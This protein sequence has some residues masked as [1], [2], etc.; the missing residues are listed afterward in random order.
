MAEGENMGGVKVAFLEAIAAVIPVTLVYFSGWAYLS[1]YVGEFGIDATQLE[2][3]FPTVLVYAFHPLQSWPVI[4]FVLIAAL[5][6]IA[7]FKLGV[8]NQAF[9][10]SSISISLVLALIV[11]SYAAKNS[12]AEMVENVW[13]G[14]KIQSFAN[15]NSADQEYT[16]CANELRLRQIIGLPTRLFLLCRSAKTPCDRG[17]MYAI[18]DDGRII[19]TANEIRSDIRVRQICE[20]K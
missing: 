6:A 20:N 3:S 4:L 5:V 19:Y 8:R 15:V 11:I 1:S 12:A 18:G 7:A 2:V 10:W 14:Q 9:W 17:V 16:R 13:R